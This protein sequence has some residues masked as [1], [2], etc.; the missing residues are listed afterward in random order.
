MHVFAHVYEGGQNIDIKY[1][2]LLL[3]TLFIVAGFLDKPE[4]LE[5]GWLV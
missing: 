4:L 3:S 5:S 2:P 1:H